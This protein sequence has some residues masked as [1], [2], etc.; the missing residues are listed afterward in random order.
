AAMA[1]GLHEVHR[2]DPGGTT[3]LVEQLMNRPPILCRASDSLHRAAALMVD[4]DCG[5]LPIVDESGRLTGMLTDRD[6]CIAAYKQG[7]PLVAMTAAQAMTQE[8]HVCRPG[9]PIGVAERMM[10]KCQVR[11][12]P[13][14]DASGHV[15]GVLS[16]GDL[17]L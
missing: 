9:D 13:V 2:G 17:A 14:V 12:L 8:V 10:S 15:V 4:N 5:A 6:I 11:R 1:P 7:L 16:I 3:M